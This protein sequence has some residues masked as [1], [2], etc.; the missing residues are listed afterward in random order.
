LRLLITC[1][2]KKRAKNKEVFSEV[3]GHVRTFWEVC[4]LA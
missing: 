4:Y 2:D 3:G 1:A